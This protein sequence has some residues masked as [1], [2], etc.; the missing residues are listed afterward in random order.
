[1]SIIVVTV[2]CLGLSVIWNILFWDRSYGISMPV[3]AVMVT[4]FVLCLKRK[5]LGKAKLTLFVHLFLI[6]YLATC[7]ALYRNSLVVNFRTF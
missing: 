4:A 2:G 5:S 1:M 3:F 7:V 6:F